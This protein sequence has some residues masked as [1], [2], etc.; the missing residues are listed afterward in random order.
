MKN[1]VEIEI[2]NLSIIPELLSPL[3]SAG[4]MNKN[5]LP[6]P[7]EWKKTLFVVI[8]IAATVAGRIVIVV[9]II[10][11]LAYSSAVLAVVEYS[12]R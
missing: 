9:V 10:A 4:I 11:V 8:E 6:P 2:S 3:T 5:V 12:S 1:N 7:T